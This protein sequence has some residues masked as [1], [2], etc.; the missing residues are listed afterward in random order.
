MYSGMRSHF[1]VLVFN[2]HFGFF[3]CGKLLRKSF[4][5]RELLFPKNV[6][7]YLSLTILFFM[8]VLHQ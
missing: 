5:K 6:L 2:L 8:V 3:V 1:S 7:K 4:L